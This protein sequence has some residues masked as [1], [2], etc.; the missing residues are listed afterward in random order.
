M[1]PYFFTRPKNHQMSTCCPGHDGR[2]NEAITKWVGTYRS[3]RSKKAAAA[4]KRAQARLARRQSRQDLQSKD[5]ELSDT[6]G[7]TL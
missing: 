5:L 4:T 6:W 7:A 3:V 1:K 2:K